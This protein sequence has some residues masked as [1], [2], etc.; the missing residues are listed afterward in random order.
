MVKKD[1]TTEYFSLEFNNFIQNQPDIKASWTAFK[2]SLKFEVSWLQSENSACLLIN[3]VYPPF[4][5]LVDY[6]CGRDKSTS[7]EIQVGVPTFSVRPTLSNLLLIEN[8]M[9]II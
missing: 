4:S 3:V 6:V 9:C 1:G 2:W 7:L 8:A 5:N